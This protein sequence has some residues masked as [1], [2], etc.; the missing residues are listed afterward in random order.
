[1]KQFD[2]RQLHIRGQVFRHGMLTAIALLLI[3]AFLQGN[4]VVWASGFHQNILILTAILAVFSVEAILRGAY[5]ATGQIRGIIIGI[6]AVCMLLLAF[7]NVRDILQGAVLLENNALTDNGFSVACLV[8]HATITIAGAIKWLG[9][10]E[11]M[12]NKRNSP[13][14]A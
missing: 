14:S 9:E 11:K 13:K 3:N 12:K 1:M 10:N 2:E 5:F 7:F 6:L 8:M 4:N